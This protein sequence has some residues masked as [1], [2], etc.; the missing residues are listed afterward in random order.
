MCQTNKE[1]FSEII[2]KLPFILLLNEFI[3]MILAKHSFLIE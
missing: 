1:L 2:K 3:Y